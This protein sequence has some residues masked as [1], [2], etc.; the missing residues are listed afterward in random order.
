MEVSKRPLH[1]LSHTFPYGATTISFS[2][3]YSSDKTPCKI[4]TTMPFQKFPVDSSDYRTSEDTCP[5]DMVATGIL[6]DSDNET[7]TLVCSPVYHEDQLDN[8]KCTTLKIPY[9]ANERADWDHIFPYEANGKCPI[10]YMLTGINYDY[11]NP[12][13]HITCCARKDIA[14]IV[15]NRDTQ[16]SRLHWILSIVILLFLIILFFWNTKKN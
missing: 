4:R 1:D 13:I 2:R 9:S 12:Y 3:I 5:T 10:G 11:E 15:G 7:T 6:L 16:I 14:D 8:N